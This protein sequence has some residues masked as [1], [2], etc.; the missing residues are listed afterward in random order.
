[1]NPFYLSHS[2]SKS[3]Y[4]VEETDTY[5]I[6]LRDN[7]ISDESNKNRIKLFF[8]SD[9]TVDQLYEVN[10]MI[11]LIKMPAESVYTMSQD[12]I[13]FIKGNL[14]SGFFPHIEKQFNKI[15]SVY[16]MLESKHRDIKKWKKLYENNNPLFR[17]IR[18]K[19]FYSYNKLNDDNIK[20]KLLS[21]ISDISPDPYC[22]N[23]TICG[24]ISKIFEERRFYMQP[25]G[26]ELPQQIFILNDINNLRG[27]ITELIT[28]D[29]LSEK[30]L[31]YLICN[32]M[33]NKNYY[34]FVINNSVALIYTRDIMNKYSSLFRYIWCYA[35]MFVYHTEQINNFECIFDIHTANKL[36]IFEGDNPYLVIPNA[37]KTYHI[38]ECGIVELAEFRRRLNFFTSGDNDIDIFA[39]MDWTNISICGEIMSMIMPLKIITTDKLNID[40]V[41]YSLDIIE[42]INSVQYIYQTIL[43]NIITSNLSAK[44][45]DIKLVTKKYL[46]V[47]IDTKTLRIKC[48]KQEIPFTYQFVIENIDNLEVK[49]H[50]YKLYV[51]QKQD[52]DILSLAKLGDKKNMP[53]FY[54]IIKLVDINN[55][56]IIVGDH[57]PEIKFIESLRYKISSKYLKND[58]K[59][60]CTT[61][62]IK[63]VSEFYL[64]CMRSYYD[65]ENCYLLPSAVVAYLTLVNNDI[66]FE[67]KTDP[68]SIIN[69]YK[70]RGYST[71]LNKFEIEEFDRIFLLH[72]EQTSLDKNENNR[73]ICDDV[74]DKHGNIVP[75]KK[76][77]IDYAYDQKN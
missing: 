46:R 37:P 47:S 61:D 6:C 4:R 24:R 42:Y 60:C 19:I 28:S 52:E 18:Q 32:L 44:L 8:D 23:E 14:L 25:I 51:A 35:W 56:C 69:K 39:N 12:A 55:V 67:K 41:C 43:Q 13:I 33:I 38:T 50:F 31:L 26:P 20:N 45:K 10:N 53:E 65:G 34:H 7:F 17:Y 73:L 1:M 5:V 71:K 77:L 76:W 62:I 30:E 22:L 72:R 57:Q 68:C 75:I 70:N 40:I 15:E 3:N 66:R 54:E 21:L 74:I 27:R 11:S 36:P 2:G 48:K 49:H 64:P 16:L 9:T 58:I 29:L 59:I 63:T